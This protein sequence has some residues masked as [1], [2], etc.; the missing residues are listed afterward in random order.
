M[1]L[2]DNDCFGVLEGVGDF[3]LDGV[4]DLAAGTQRDDDGGTD[5]G[6]V[7]LLN[8]NSDGTVKNQHKISNTSGG[9]TGVLEDG[10]GFGQSVAAIGDF[11]GNGV[12]DLAV[13]AEDDDDGGLS[14]GTV[15]LLMMNADGTVN[16]RTRSATPSVISAAD[17]M[18][19]ISSGR[20]SSILVTMTTTVFRTSP[21]VPKL[22]A[23]A[24]NQ[25]VQRGY[26]R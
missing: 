12:T 9:F 6:A 2:D 3:D 5:R 18:P 15:W 24:G 13:G 4:P 21:W 22:T 19:A 10:D 20:R 7:W 16:N 17:L 23:T 25:G 1:S 14:S 11:D 26:F 8:L